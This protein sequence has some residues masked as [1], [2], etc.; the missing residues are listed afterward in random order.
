[1]KENKIYTNPECTMLD[2]EFEGCVLIGSNPG[3]G[4]EDGETEEGGEI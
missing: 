1:M 3:F 2:M 4:G